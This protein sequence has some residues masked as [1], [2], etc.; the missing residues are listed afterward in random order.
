VIKTVSYNRLRWGSRRGMLE[1][2]LILMPFV[3]RIYPTLNPDDQALYARLLECEDQDL[4]AWL[5]H[6]QPAPEDWQREIIHLIRLSISASPQ[7]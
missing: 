4:F 6:R 7:P 2:D 1:L 5:L 3:E